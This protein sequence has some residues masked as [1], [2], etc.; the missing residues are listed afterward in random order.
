MHRPDDAGLSQKTTAQR[1]QNATYYLAASVSLLTFL[2]YLKSLRKGFVNRDHPLYVFENPHIRS[3]NPAFFKWAFL[4]FYAANRHPLTWMSHAL[5]YAVWGLNPLVHHLTN[6]L[7]HAANT[8]IVVVLVTRLLQTSPAGLNSLNS[9]NGLNKGA[10]IAA[11]VTGLLFGLH[12]VH[13]ESVAWVAERK[14]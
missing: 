2:V 9:L 7:L 1:T 10:L 14:V 11:G 8:F 6:T 13:V 4:D 12:P 5:D 3:L